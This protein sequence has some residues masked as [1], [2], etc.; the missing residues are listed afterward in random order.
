MP[1]IL[2]RGLRLLICARKM[3]VRRSINCGKRRT[4]SQVADECLERALLMYSSSTVRG[5]LIVFFISA[6]LVACATA[7]ADV[8]NDLAT[9]RVPR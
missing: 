7:V 2:L 6:A 8:R 3:E 9:F 1:N 5:G 4:Y